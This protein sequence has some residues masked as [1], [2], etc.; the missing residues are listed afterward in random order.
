M[1]C[2][3]LKI[4]EYEN[5]IL[6]NPSI[7]GLPEDL[8]NDNC[9]ACCVPPPNSCWMCECT[10][11]HSTSNNKLNCI[12][13]GPNAFYTGCEN[14]E[15]NCVLE[16]EIGRD[17]EFWAAEE[18]PY[19]ILTPEG[20]EIY[21]K[22]SID[23][24]QPRWIDLPDGRLLVNDNIGYPGSPYWSTLPLYDNYL[25]S[26]FYG[27]EIRYDW[28]DEN[29][30]NHTTKAFRLWQMDCS[31]NFTNVTKKYIDSVLPGGCIAWDNYPEWPPVPDDYSEGTRYPTT[32]PGI[33]DCIITRDGRLPYPNQQTPVPMP[34]EF[35]GLV[36]GEPRVCPGGTAFGVCGESGTTCTIDQ[37]PPVSFSCDPSLSKSNCPGI[38]NEGQDCLNFDCNA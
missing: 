25:C 34:D 12:D 17:A 24:S 28:Y 7:E 27:Q 35:W 36:S 20:S 3:R 37:L 38:W 29:G 32:K 1:P 26:C 13:F 19:V 15:V 16:A 22:G 9:G 23:P 21:H 5:L 14:G 31:G 33:G 6:Q 2:K 18:C 10:F 4:Q 8:C 30:N 11:N